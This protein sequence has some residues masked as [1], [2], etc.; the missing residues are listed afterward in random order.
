MKQEKACIRVLAVDD[1]PMIRQ[2]I[3]LVLSEE[4]DIKVVAEAASGHEALDWLRKNSCDVV[5]L[6]ISMD[7]MD[8]IETLK[9]M[10]REGM[11]AP[12]VMLSI[13]PEEQYAVRAIKA[14]AAGYL[15]K[16]SLPDELVAAVRAVHAG[17]EYISAAISRSLIA[18]MRNKISAD[19]P[20]EKLSDREFQILCLIAEGK[21]VGEVAAELSIS[22]KTVSTHRSRL[23]AKMNLHTN[24]QLM[25]YAMEHQL[26][27]P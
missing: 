3:R 25:R 21:T 22:I 27:S 20:H 13:H 2:G 16:T 1:H 19:A 23:M 26:E 14:G 15:G 4:A 18:H 10:R 12:V 9:Q 17:G 8:G 7:G 11:D 24:V 5:T 6:D